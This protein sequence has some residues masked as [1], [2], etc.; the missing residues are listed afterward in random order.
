MLRSVRGIR[1]WLGARPLTTALIVLTG[2]FLW[3]VLPALSSDGSF[4]HNSAQH[5]NSVNLSQLPSEIALA[6]TLIVIVLWLG[7]SKETR[8]TTRPAWGGIWYVAGPLLFMAGLLAVR[9]IAAADAGAL[10]SFTVSYILTLLFLTFLVGIFEE[11]LFRGVVLHGFEARFGALIAVIAS[12]VLFGAMHYVNWVG[13]QN[14]AETT[15]Q[16]ISASLSGILYGALALRARSIWPGV[17]LHGLWDA[18]VTISASLTVDQPVD[19]TETAVDVAVSPLIE[20][21]VFGVQF[22]EPIYGVIVLIGY[23]I[24]V[25]SKR[26]QGQ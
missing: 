24:W 14:F 26:R 5:A 23:F 10:P 15:D 13:G 22:F 11:T 2:Y 7:W 19:G 1:D 25:R 18:W 16:V 20:V 6:G 21:L 9:A 3:F 17:M 8:L 4:G 12:S